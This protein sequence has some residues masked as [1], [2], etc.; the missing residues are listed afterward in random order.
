[1]TNKSLSGGDIAVRRNKSLKNRRIISAVEVIE[2]A[3][4]VVVIATV[5]DWVGRDGSYVSSTI[6]ICDCVITPCVILIRCIECSI[7]AVELGD[8][9]LEILNVGVRLIHAV[10]GRAFVELKAY[11]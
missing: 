6:G 7:R 10:S 5:T 4:G 11:G 1:M 3:F 8:V 9:T 2:V